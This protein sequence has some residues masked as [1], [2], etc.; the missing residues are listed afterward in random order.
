METK[1][2]DIPAIADSDLKKILNEFHIS[3]KIENHE[4]I[5]YCCETVIN[6]DNIGLLKII[7]NK[8]HLVCDSSACVEISQ[9]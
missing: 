9:K 5:C 6:W 3:E 4:I 7:D 2:I 8:I 1:R